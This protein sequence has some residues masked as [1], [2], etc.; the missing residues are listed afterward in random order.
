MK[1]KIVLISCIS[2]FLLI[3]VGFSTTEKRK[4][5]YAYNEKVYLTEVP[6]R[7]IIRFIEN[8]HSRVD[9]VSL[10]V[11]LKNQTIQWPDD[12][13]VIV[14]IKDLSNKE[15]LLS[16]FNAQNDVKSCQS[17]YSTNSIDELGIT[18]EFLVKFND[19][20]SQDEITNIHK[21]NNVIVVEST[22]LGQ[23]L[24]VPKGA[25]VLN[26]AN[27]YQESGL[28]RFSQPNFIS[29]LVFN[30]VIPNDTYFSNQFYLHNTGQ[31]FAD[32]H[33]GTA[34]ADIHA[35]EAWSV[36]KGSSN[37][38]VAVIDDGVT[39]DHPDLPNTRQLRLNNSNTGDGQP[40]DPSPTG[41]NNHGNSCAGII[42]ATQNNNQG[43]SGIAPECRVMPIRPVTSDGSYTSSKLAA[44]FTFAKDNGARIISCSWTLG[45][46][47]PNY[48]P[49]IHD[50]ISSAVAS[51]CVVVISAGNTANHV[52]HT[53]GSIQFPAN[54]DIAGVLTVG[55]S[56]RDDIQ[57]NYSP[58]SDP[59]SSQN[60][61]ID[62]VAPSNRAFS[63]QILG[64]TKEVWTIDTPLDPGDNSVHSTDGGLLPV[65]GE[66]LPATGTNYLSYTAR[67]GGTSASAPQVAAVAALV[68]SINPNL[69]QQQVFNIITSSADKV[70]NYA[71]YIGRSNELGY[72]RLNAYNAVSQALSTI[73]TVTG[74]NFSCSFSPNSTFI[75]HNRPS[76]TTVHW[77]KSSNLVYVSGNVT[78]NYVVKA[79]SAS[80]AEWVRPTIYF[81]TDSV[82]LPQYPIWIGTPV[83]TVTGDATISCNNTTHYFAASANYYANASNFTWDLVPLNGNYLSPYGYQNDHCAITFYNPWSAS[84]YTVRARAQNSCGTGGYGTTDIW[85]HYCRGF[86][87]SPNPASETVT[88]TKTVSGATEGIT[89]A[90]ISEDATTI[91][92]IRII[93]FYGALHY[94]ATKSGDS[95][96]F[97]VSS[98]KDGQYIVQIAGGNNTANLTL[99]VKH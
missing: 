41:N 70:G 85:I 52:G 22:E 77:T 1:T 59:N 78:D 88:V 71:Y 53:N 80:S 86:L 14:Q 27:S 98:L 3:L 30:Q 17:L 67:F 36:T 6:N 83:L 90:A 63:N 84:A 19:N 23:L 56:D 26:I 44:A 8:K 97:P 43:I 75:L 48:S 7:F 13:T 5:Y 37:I 60:Q 96:T 4:F 29:K 57:A 55:A 68:L 47:D 11:N 87:L 91:Y 34:G 38:K 58:T 61:I 10:S 74:P 35:P 25:D 20:V 81:G 45:S 50:A 79:S 76:G 69:T 64:E 33:S 9:N 89:N 28:T 82:V 65:V 72:G 21:K 73:C 15:L 46:T 92:T 31:V 24:K 51:G 93:D 42:A 12:S 94:S 39:S 95:F 18:D 66:I 32:G 49:V 16:N 99:I 40:N 54:V 62:I 2:L